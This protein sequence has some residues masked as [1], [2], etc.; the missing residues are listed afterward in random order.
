VPY[1]VAWPIVVLVVFGF[2]YF[3][4]NRSIY[5][6][7]KYPEGRWE[8]QTPLGAS[9]AW[10]ET[11]DHIRL[12]GWWKVQEGAR[13][14]T[15]YL[16]GNAGNISHRSDTIREITAAGSSILM[17]DYRGYGK[18]AGWPTEK[19]LYRDADAAYAYLIGLGYRDGQIVVH[20]ESLGTAVA[21][22]L[23]S[24]QQ[25]AAL[26]LE[27]PFTSGAD[28]A[29]SQVPVLGP[30]LVRTFN[31]ASKIG[32]IGAPKLFIQGD[33]DLVIPHRFAQELFESATGPKEFWIVNG[34]G[35]ND[36]LETAGRRYREKLR[37]FYSSILP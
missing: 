4:A 20:G 14:A 28:V 9:D 8:E 36:I 37:A 12:N 10:I 18:S 19:G 7:V 26:I 2:L 27:A 34:A 33:R 15:L 23:A 21:V 11:S 30:M 17:L 31:S 35:H 29:G 6:P 3:L 32:K 1:F 25:C 22:D 5:Y 24:R 13:W 16:H